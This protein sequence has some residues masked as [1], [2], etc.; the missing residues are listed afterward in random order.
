MIEQDVTRAKQIKALSFPLAAFLE[1]LQN[2][3]E[4]IVKN[5]FI[6]HSN[7]L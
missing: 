6:Q 7:H 1:K 3:E 2:W 4:R 5:V